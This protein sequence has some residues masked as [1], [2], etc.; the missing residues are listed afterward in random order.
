MSDSTRDTH[1]REPLSPLHAP[2]ACNLHEQSNQAT[3]ET[4]P[5]TVHIALVDASAPKRDQLAKSTKVQHKPPHQTKRKPSIERGQTTRPTY[6][7]CPSIS[8]VLLHQFSFNSP[9]NTAKRN[10]VESNQPPPRNRKIKIT[11]HRRRRKT[12]HKS[13][14]NNTSRP[15]SPLRRTRNTQSRR[16]R[17]RE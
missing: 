7:S 13:S 4:L 17:V 15:T 6:A 2:H 12:C 5:T 9:R 1:T 3:H 16:P 11:Q 8:L 10:N 14:S